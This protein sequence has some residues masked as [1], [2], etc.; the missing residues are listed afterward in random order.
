MP[1]KKKPFKMNPLVEKAWLLRALSRTPDRSNMLD[2]THEI[3]SGSGTGDTSTVNAEGALGEYQLIEDSSWAALQ[4][5]FPKKYGKKKFRDVA[6]D[7]I[8]ARDAAN[9]Y[10]QVLSL[11]LAND[12]KV[13]PTAEAY[14]TAYHSGSKNVAKGTLGPHGQQYNSRLRALYKR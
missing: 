2:V 10:Y 11:E 1:S 12:Y 5:H 13:A 9:D 6:L 3:E 14:G 7:P 8:Q 4:K